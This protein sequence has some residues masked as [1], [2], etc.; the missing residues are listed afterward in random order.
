MA[1]GQSAESEGAMIVT[2]EHD[3]VVERFRLRIRRDHSHRDEDQ[4]R[5]EQQRGRVVVARDF[6]AGYSDWHPSE[7]VEQE[8]CEA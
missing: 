5:V 6:V 7:P 8:E 3:Y 4:Q 1:R 2:D